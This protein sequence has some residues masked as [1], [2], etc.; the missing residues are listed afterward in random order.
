MMSGNRDY[1]PAFSTV[2]LRRDIR[3]IRVMTDMVKFERTLMFQ[4][5]TRK[6]YLLN[7]NDFLPE[8]ARLRVERISPNAD[9]LYLIEWA[10][11]NLARVLSVLLGEPL[12]DYFKSLQPATDMLGLIQMQTVPTS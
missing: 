2:L 3:L 6:P 7:L 1:D 4:W 12:S 8:T 10:L 11:T 5:V 9:D